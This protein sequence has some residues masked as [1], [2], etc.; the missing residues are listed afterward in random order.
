MWKAFKVKVQYYNE[1]NWER[2]DNEASVSDHSPEDFL[3]CQFFPNCYTE[4]ILS[5]S[6]YEH[7][8]FMDSD[9]FILKFK[10]KCNEKLSNK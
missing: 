3:R 5:L 10:Y 4:S 9:F 7:T 6:K 1:A 8:N 2:S